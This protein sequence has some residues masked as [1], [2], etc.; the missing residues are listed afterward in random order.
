MVSRSQGSRRQQEGRGVGEDRGR[1]S[2]H[3]RGRMAALQL[4]RPDGGTGEAPPTLPRKPQAGDV[5]EEVGGSAP[6]G[7]RPDLQEEIKDA[8][9]PEARRHGSWEH[10]EDPHG[11]TR[12]R[13]GT[14]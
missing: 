6:V 4:R 14:A 12:S 7:W 2:G 8:E 10:Q 9:K 3:P 5:R 11:S 1:G 13:R